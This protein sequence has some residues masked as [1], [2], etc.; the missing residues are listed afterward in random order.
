MLAVHCPRC[1][2]PAPVS[3]ASPD[4]MACAA[5]HYRGPPP[6]DASHGL[7]AAAHVLFQTDVRRRQLSEALRRTLATASR[8]HARLLVV[9]ALAAVP[10]T[11]FCAVMLLGMWVSPNTEGNLVMGAMTVAAW[12]GTVG[13]GAA[14]LAFVRRRQRRIEEACAARP[15][16]APG[17]PAACHVCGAPL[18]GGDGGGGVI[19]RCGFCAA[20]N[21]V[22][23][24]VLER[25]R[26]RQVVLLRSFEQAVSAELAAFS[27]ATSGAAAAVVAIALAVPAAVVVIAMIVVITAESR[28][29]PADVTVRYVVVGTPVGQC[30]GKIAV[31]K[32]GSTV[33]LF[34][35]FRRD[36][37]PEEQLIAPG[38]PI[39][40]LAP[41]SFVGRAV[42]STRGAGVVVEVFSSP[43]TGNTAEVRRD[44]GTSFN[45][46]IA[47]LCLDARPAR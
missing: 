17:E 41:G 6:A 8:R 9:F 44:D 43:L 30:V 39:E 20:D 18:D 25:A 38:S 12:L 42:T 40:D 47:G 26:A 37:L 10:V 5:C 28:R 7:R 3:L 27:R 22:A 32:D 14:V 35:S 34:S 21:L 16:A 31:R 45:S 11:G 33:V 13:T 15:P 36:E 4:L 46:S 29:V 2:R 24:A 23:P 19:A 1:G